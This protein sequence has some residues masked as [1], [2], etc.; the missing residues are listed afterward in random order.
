MS[1]S[2]VSVVVRNMSDCPIFLKKG[3]RWCV[4]L[5]SLVP[6]AELSPK[7]EATLGTENMKKP[8]S[9]T[10]QQEKLLEKLNLDSLSLR[11][12]ECSSSQGACFDL[13]QHLCARW[14]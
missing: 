10:V 11:Y 12:L 3:Y 7:M 4:V 14:E 9:V 13:S 2:K 5:A 6:L 1:S 8:M